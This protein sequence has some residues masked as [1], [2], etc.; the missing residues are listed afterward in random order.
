MLTSG[1]ALQKIQQQRSGVQAFRDLATRYNPR[2]QARSLAKLQ[3]IMQFDL[4]QDPSGVT[5]Q[6]RRVSGESPT[7]TQNTPVAH[8]WF[9]TGL[10]HHE[11]DSGELLGGETVMAVKPFNVNGRSSHASR[12]GV[13]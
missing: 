4:G 10:R 5:G 3:E 1:S 2:S 6:M 11:T 8:L 9:T 7:G 12:R 13:R